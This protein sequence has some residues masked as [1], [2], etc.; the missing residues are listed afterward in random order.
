[1]VRY[2]PSGGGKFM[3]S[4]FRVAEYKQ[5]QI[6]SKYLEKAFRGKSPAQEKRLTIITGLPGSGK[7]TAAAKLLQKI[8]IRSSSAVM[9]FMP[10]IPIFL[11]FIKNTPPA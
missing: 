9:I 8:K 2:F 3:A 4:E 11:I 7:S 10:F 6:V 5:R 1:M